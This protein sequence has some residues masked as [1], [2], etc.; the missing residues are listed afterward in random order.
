MIPLVRTAED[1][2]AFRHRILLLF[3]EGAGWVRQVLEGGR[4]LNL[5][6]A[7]SSVFRRLFHHPLLHSC[8]VVLAADVAG[9]FGSTTA[10]GPLR[11]TL[12][13]GAKVDEAAIPIPCRATDLAPIVLVACVI[14]S[15][16]SIRHLAL[17]GGGLS[18]TLPL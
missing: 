4:V 10:V 11:L 15:R 1:L 3:C 7:T 9:D 17:L 5:S 8:L 14:D 12:E 13:G 6:L 16:D 18:L 2:S